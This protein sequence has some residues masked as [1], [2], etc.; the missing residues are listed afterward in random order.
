MAKYPRKP[1]GKEIKP[2]FFVFCEGESEESYVSFLKSKYRVPIHI[3]TKVAKNKINKK[4]V[5][6]VLK[7]LS[8]HKKDKLFLFYDLD[9]PEILERLQSIRNSILVVSNPCIEFWYILHTCNHAP[10]AT[11]QQCVDQLIRI[12]KDY[13]KGSICDKLRNRL[14][15]GEEDACKRARRLQLYNNPS[16]SVFRLID[17]LKKVNF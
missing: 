6:R 17:E 4:Y 5:D 9:V 1:L 15:T 7:P 2:T 13:R 12:Y 16:T 11:S 3:K 14:M 8:K 10:Q